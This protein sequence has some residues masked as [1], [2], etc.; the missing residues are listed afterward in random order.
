L[1]ETIN[2]ADAEAV[3]I[4]TPID[5]RRLIQINKPVTR[6]TYNMDDQSAQELLDIL[7]SKEMV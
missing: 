7:K 2:K 1:E 4:G 3:L 5:L 6:V